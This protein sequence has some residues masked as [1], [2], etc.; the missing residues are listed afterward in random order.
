M[1][2]VN[3]SSEQLEQFNTAA[4]Y[5]KNQEYDKA[6]EIYIELANHGSTS[7]QRF[8]GWMYLSGEGVEK[9]IE[10]AEF[11]FKKSADGD[12]VEAQFGLG[13]IYLLKND[14]EQAKYWFEKSVENK[15]MPS[16]FRLAKIYLSESENNFNKGFDLLKVAAKSGHIA[17]GKNYALLLIK[18]KKGLFNR[19]IG[20]F[21]FIKIV[22]MIFILATREPDSERLLK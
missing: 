1:N 13:K 3:Y 17:S 6:F 9:N 8:I 2:S 7:S 21:L 4:E 22:I 15:F 11:W 10:Q 19:V 5:C 16:Y 18:G 20:M 14:I 12:D